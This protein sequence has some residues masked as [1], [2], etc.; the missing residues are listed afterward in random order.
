RKRSMAL[1][2]IGDLFALPAE[3]VCLQKEIRTEDRPLL[4]RFDR[5]RE[6]AVEIADFADTAALIACCDLVISIDTSV[7]HLAGA[8]GKPVWV[9]LPYVPDWRWLLD[10]EDNPW[11]PTA[12]LFRQRRFGDWPGVIRAVHEELLRSFDEGHW[13]PEAATPAQATLTE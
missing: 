2:T 5:L 10:R 11:Y 4:P 7:A 6:F 13:P 3:W 8:M 9:L 1:E 12:R